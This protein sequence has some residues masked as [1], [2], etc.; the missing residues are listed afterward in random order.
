VI[1]VE[2]APQVSESS[3]S[4]RTLPVNRGAAKLGGL[5]GLSDQRHAAGN[6]FLEHDALSDYCISEQ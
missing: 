6:P 2:V 5:R 1:P 3:V 4:P